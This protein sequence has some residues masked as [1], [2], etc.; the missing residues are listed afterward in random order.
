MTSQR[1]R[2]LLLPALLGVLILGH[3]AISLQ[4]HAQREGVIRQKEA[5]SLLPATLYK[6]IALEYEN[7]VADLV[8]SR[9]MS[10]YG[11][12]LNRR[13]KVD[14]DT[15]RAIYQRLDA[16]SQLDPYFVDPYYFGQAV[17]AWGAGCRGKP[18]RYWIGGGTIGRMI[19]F[20]PSLW[21]STRFTSCMTKRWPGICSW[22]R[23]SGQGQAPWW[24]CWPRGWHRKAA[25][26]RFR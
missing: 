15:N 11:G 13:E 10:F 14:A 8:V 23:R 5:L 16:A 9:T 19:G 2:D 22:K 24:D 7:L 12:T 6:F 1:A 18:T 3:L 25:G 4:M 20:C 17:L 26:L 21:G